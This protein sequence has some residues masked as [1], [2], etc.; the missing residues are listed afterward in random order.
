M[1]CNISTKDSRIVDAERWTFITVLRSFDELGLGTNWLDL[2]S[3]AAKLRKFLRPTLCL[4]YS[5]KSILDELGRVAR[6]FSSGG[7]YYNAAGN[8][9][10]VSNP[11]V[12]P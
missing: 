6:C 5:V 10:F 1:S 11:I 12:K 4:S 8:I 7:T 3:F 2:R 9:R